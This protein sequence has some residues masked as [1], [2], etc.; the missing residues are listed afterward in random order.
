M[1]IKIGSSSNRKGVTINPSTVLFNGNNVKQ[2]KNNSKEIWAYAIPLVPILT[3][4]NGSDGGVASCYKANASGGGAYL[5]FDGNH[6]T[7]TDMAYG[8]SVAIGKCY[9]QYKF[10]VPTVVKKVMVYLTSKRTQHKLYTADIQYS[11]DGITWHTL[12]TIDTTNAPFDTEI[13][14]DINN[15][16]GI[17]ALY[18]RLQGKTNA[19]GGNLII[20]TMQFYGYQN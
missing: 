1:G 11:D 5:A 3:S 18:W 14:L 19:S 2:I 12:Y 6:D 20:S 13:T 15:V 16:N 7:W 10:A 4:D 17:S 9:I 8:G